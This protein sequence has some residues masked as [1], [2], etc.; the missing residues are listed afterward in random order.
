MSYRDKRVHHLEAYAEKHGLSP[1]M[2]GDHKGDGLPRKHILL[3]NKVP[4]LTGKSK[5][6]F[7]L[8]PDDQFNKVIDYNLLDEVKEDLYKKEEIHDMAHYLNSS[9]VLCYN[10]FRPLIDS[11]GHPSRALIELFANHGISITEKASCQFEYNPPFKGTDGSNE[12]TEIDFYVEDE[13]VGTRV[14]MEIKYTESSFGPWGKPKKAVFERYYERMISECT[15]LYTEKIA[16]N[17]DF[18]YNYQLYRNAL[19]VNSANTFTVFMFP[20]ESS[21]LNEQYTKFSNMIKMENNIQVWYWEDI[22]SKEQF[23]LL[24]EK[25]FETYPEEISHHRSRR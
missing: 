24:Y 10:F 21:T 13:Y 1:L 18:K 22:V 23:P 5:S 17:D 11:D 16:Y 19:R 20:K 14:Y 3:V 15:G 9:Q 7:V 25:Y 6:G 4:D 8:D 2:G 12:G